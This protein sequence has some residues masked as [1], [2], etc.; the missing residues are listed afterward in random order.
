MHR[1]FDTIPPSSDPEYTRPPEPRYSEGGD[2]DFRRHQATNHVITQRLVER[3]SGSGPGQE[4]LYGVNPKVRCFAATLSSQYRF[5]KEQMEVDSED[6]DDD[7][8]SSMMKNIAPFS[9]GLRLRVD[10]EELDGPLKIQPNSRL[11][12][13]RFPTYEEQL[14]YSGVASATPDDEEFEDVEPDLYA[15][16]GE[17]DVTSSQPLVD[18]YQRVDPSFEEIEIS[19][20]KL[21]NAASSGDEITE[22]L[23]STLDRVREDVVTD[24]ETVSIPKDGVS[25]DEWNEVPA[26]AME[27]ESSFERHLETTFSGEKRRPLWSAEIRIEVD[28]RSDGKYDVAATL[29]NTHG[30]DFESA[31]EANEEWQT[32]L[33]DATIA[34]EA[35]GGAFQPF[36]SEKIKGRYEY[37][38]DIWGLG[39]NCS[40]E[41]VTSDPVTKVVTD[42]V[43]IHRQ[44]KYVSRETIDAPFDA[45]ADGNFEPVLNRIEDEMRQAYDQYQEIR[46]EVTKGKTE[47]AKQSFDEM[48]TQF[49]S[50]RERFR[51]GKELLLDE[52]NEDARTAFAA[53]NRT[54]GEMGE[55]YEDWRLFQIVY[56]VMSIPDIVSQSSP[57]R[58]IRDSLDVCDI[59]FF[60]TGG[61]KTEAY[62]GLVVFAAFLDR[63]RGKDYGMTALTKFPLRLLSL[64]QLQ[65]ITE[66]LCSAEL[67][68]RDHKKMGGERFSVGYFVGKNN[69][70][71]SIEEDGENVVRL[72][73]ESEEHKDKWL[74]VPE[75]P[76]CGEE[77][78][79]ITGDLERL[80][81]VHECTN[82]ECEEVEHQ[83][84][85]SAELPVYV[86]DNEVYRYVPTFVVSTIDKIAIFGQNRRSRGL[87]GQVKYRCPDHGYTT[88]EGCLVAG[89]GTPEDVRCD[90]NTPAGMESVEPSDPPSI[91]IQDELHLLR[92]EFGAF[93]SHYETFIQELIHQY[94]DSQWEMKVVAAT[95]T[96]EGA[97]NQVQ[98]L[99]RKEPNEFPS[100]GPRLKQSFYAYEDPHRL[101][102]QMIG[103]IPRSVGPSRAMNIVMREYAKITQWYESNPDQLYDDIVSVASDVVAGPL[104]FSSDQ[105]TRRREILDVLDAYKVQ[106]AY[107]ISK[108]Q[109]DLLNRSIKQ[110]INEQLAEDGDEYERLTPVSMTGETDMETVRDALSRLEAD[111]PDEPIDAV[112]ATNMI[113]HGVDVDRFNFMSFHGMPR[114]TAEYIQAYSRVGRKYTGSVFLLFNAMRARDRSHYGRFDHYHQ[115]QDLLVEAT[116]LE[117]WAEY[118]IECTLPGV[119]VGL[120]LQY[121]DL[122]HETEFDKRIYN[123]DGLREAVKADVVQREELLEM[124][125]RAYDVQDATENGEGEIGARIYRE[126][127]EQQ[128]DEIWNCLMNA[129]PIINDPREAGLKKF[130]GNI[131]DNESEDIR[132]PMRSLRDIDEQIPVSLD[133]ATKDMIDTM[134]DRG[135]FDE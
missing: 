132:K 96:I 114:N 112:V 117:R 39:Q 63:L 133:L 7:A 27:D 25:Y 121:Y 99:Y 83:G 72:A 18:V 87:L 12:V 8:A 86:V 16:G 65:R 78:V 124:T 103:A 110:M 129:D 54:F 2:A 104:S 57:Q 122:H 115:Y 120:L 111:D 109:S 89:R 64:Q 5:Q 31:E 135:D 79:E 125:F 69:T 102:R 34:V 28:R 20:A 85:D 33:F 47:D 45:L 105:E 108:S 123:I 134:I 94:T 126:R 11:Y 3:I 116:P 21:R 56:I 6:G 51:R 59:I 46:E 13:K 4:T 101:G 90:H 49:E 128:F 82:P 95:A 81:I 58:D 71:N 62:L 66:V 35:P 131:L 50:E 17:V 74:I 67:I 38:G 32:Y 113:S 26:S 93:D 127:I 75:C 24:S 1:K 97:R 106:I 76:F 80:R 9:T 73:K 55:E 40:A 29:I 52:S 48:L 118:A 130:I 119:V 37:D 84:G 30:E 70:P 77:S 98:S 60:P 36:K 15:D 92:E 68:R 53:L 41:P 100:R 43:P 22:S 14:Q 107:T 91:L 10:P 88:E 61:G 19:K 44:P 42:P 23:S